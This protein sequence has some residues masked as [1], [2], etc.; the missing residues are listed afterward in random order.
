MQEGATGS[1]A[2][3]YFQLLLSV[4]HCLVSDFDVYLHVYLLLQVRRLK[5]SAARCFGAT[6]VTKRHM[7]AVNVSPIDRGHVLLVPEPASCLPQVNW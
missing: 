7:L 6:D 2:G 1:E 4:P 5:P 3:V